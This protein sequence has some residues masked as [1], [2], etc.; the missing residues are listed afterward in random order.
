MFDSLTAQS[1]GLVAENK[2]TPLALHRHAWELVWGVWADIL[3][4]F[5]R[6][7]TMLCIMIKYLHFGLIFSKDIFT[8]VL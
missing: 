7:S 8:D 4:T 2:P 5:P 3:F 1:P 6:F